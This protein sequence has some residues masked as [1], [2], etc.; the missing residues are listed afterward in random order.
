[1]SWQIQSWMFIGKTDAQLKLQYF[2][3]MIWKTDSLY[4][5]THCTQDSDEDWRQ[6]EEDDRGW[7]G[8]MASLTRWT[9]VWA[10]SRSWRWTGV[11]VC[12]S[13]WG[14][15]VKNDWETELNWTL[16][17]LSSSMQNLW[18]VQIG[19]KQSLSWTVY[20]TDRPSV[21]YLSPRV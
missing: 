18:K 9:W 7:E 8:W 15:R 5:M 10:S 13:P 4:P 1:M 12:C 20:E 2:G 21:F 14:R 16:N 17:T 6:E 19:S 11:Q 3:H